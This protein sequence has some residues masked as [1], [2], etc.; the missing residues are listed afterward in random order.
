MPNGNKEVHLE[1]IS[2][3]DVARCHVDQNLWYEVWQQD[4]MH[5]YGIASVSL[6]EIKL[7]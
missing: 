5:M 3:A 7:P 6:Y 2:H 1:T 4:N